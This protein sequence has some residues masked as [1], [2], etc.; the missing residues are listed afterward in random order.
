MLSPS[1]LSLPSK[2]TNFRKEVRQESTILS[3]SSSDKR[4]SILCAPPGTGKSL[5]YYSLIRL[6]SARGLILVGTK[7]LE[8]QLMADFSSSGL[9][10]IRGH[11][12]YPCVTLSYDDDTGELED[13][14]CAS[15]RN[16]RDCLYRRDV[17]YS[18]SHNEVV[19]N[20]AHWA[21]CYKS[22]DP[23][24]L[25]HFDLLVI[26]EAHSIRKLLT[27]Y[28]AI[29]L[30]NK[31]LSQYLNL[32]LPRLPLSDDYSPWLEWLTPAIKLARTKYKEL[33]NNKASKRDVGIITQL[34]KTLA[35]LQ[36]ELILNPDNWKITSNQSKF[37]S[38]PLIQF[39]PV[40]ISQF[41]E[42]YLFRNIPRILLTSATIARDDA[43]DLGIANNDFDFYEIQSAFDAARRQVIYVPTSPPVKV[44]NRITIGEKRIWINRI[45]SIVEGRL[46]RKGLIQTRSYERKDDI[47]A[48]SKYSFLMIDFSKGKMREALEKFKQSDP[49][50]ILIGPA[51]E[52]GIDLPLELCLYL[53]LAKLPFLDSRDVMVK[54][55][56]QLDPT[57]KNREVA[58]SIV[59]S[60]SRGMRSKN[61]FCEV[62][63]VDAHCEWFMFKRSNH[64]LYPKYFVD[65]FRWMS[66]VPEA[67]SLEEIGL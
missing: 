36:S 44:D 22:E 46:D 20:L 19:S 39:S 16:G 6:L 26:D 2:F 14:E 62:F 25:G 11:S 31:T 1:D 9:F 18:L 7:N 50:A 5:I 30:Y 42:E 64:Y 35:R 37:S 40:D 32:H 48:I 65:A 54:A 23:H 47:L 58:R 12:N 10:D 67:P 56:S 38:K 63:I 29:K 55:R 49:P 43:K 3:L 57:Y 27:D 28:V 66:S 51:M 60:T 8:S 17:N 15:R 34:G 13:L 45:D 59:Q 4:F 33:V 53:I 21:Q 41:T 61:D 24:R 52:E